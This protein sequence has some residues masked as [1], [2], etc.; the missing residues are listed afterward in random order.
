[1]Q[2]LLF[3]LPTSRSQIDDT[4]PP[5]FVPVEKEPQIV[6]EVIPKYPEL[7]QRAGI[8]GRVI[9]KIWVDKDGK[10]HKAV[11]LKSDADIFQPTRNGCCYA[12][13]GSLRQL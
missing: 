2:L 8:E 9:V 11:V 10:P 3:L 1:M 12:D 13:I 6:N 5:D 7:A 4:P